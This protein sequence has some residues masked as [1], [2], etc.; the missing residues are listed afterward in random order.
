MAVPL[1]IHLLLRARVK[2][3]DW[4][5][6]RFLQRAMLRQKRQLRLRTL[7]QLLAR[8][9]IIAALVLAAAQPSMPS[10]SGRLAV[11]EPVQHLFL[12]D[13]SLSSRAVDE[14]DHLSTF[15][16][17]REHILNIV[18]SAQ[19][20]DSFQ[21]WLHGP[22]QPL[23]HRPTTDAVQAELALLKLEPS[24]ERGNLVRSLNEL[25]YLLSK[26]EQ[27]SQD[28][29]IAQPIVHV[30]TDMQ[31]AQW[32][33]SPE[34]V[35]S[36]LK[37]LEQQADL[38]II[39]VGSQSREN[40]AIVQVEQSPNVLQPWEPITLSVSVRNFGQRRIETQV[41]FMVD[42][43]TRSTTPVSLEA[44]ESKTVTM[45]T[46]ISDI[47]WHGIELLLKDDALNDDNHYFTAVRVVDHLNVLL[48]DGTPATSKLSRPCDFIE[49][50]LTDKV[51][52]N[53][54]WQ[55]QRID[56]IDLLET[57]LDNFDLIYLCDL[58]RYSTHE[59][60]RLSNFLNQGGGV[61]ISLGPATDRENLNQ[62]FGPLGTGMLP[63][64]LEPTA[65]DS[66]QDPF[67]LTLS[68]PVQPLGLPFKELPESFFDAARAYQFFP[69]TKS[70]DS[71]S[72]TGLV[73]VL[74]TQQGDAILL[75]NS[76][77]QKQPTQ[78]K[79]IVE[80]PEQ[81]HLPNQGLGR[82][83]LITTS[84]DEQWGSW[85]AWPGFLPLIHELS[86]EMA[87]GQLTPRNARNRTPIGSIIHDH[88]WIGPLQRFSSDAVRGKPVI[89]E[90]TSPGLY[91]PADYDNEF[92]GITIANV[93]LRDSDLMQKTQS[94]TDE[95]TGP[96]ET[97]VQLTQPMSDSN[98]TPSLALWLLL[99][100]M[101]FFVT[102]RFL[103]INVPFGVCFFAGIVL[104]TASQ[105][106]ASTTPIVT[107]C[108]GILTSVMVFIAMRA[109]VASP[110]IKATAASD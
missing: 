78:T 75:T 103:A 108:I 51:S 29:T 57:E 42:G 5:A 1:A 71:T 59:A 81:S 79:T 48:V 27:A 76:R 65:I 36:G 87:G 83:A 3:I 92:E 82:L 6:M 26:Y 4:G 10:A 72:S 37:K 39:N 104:A 11:H 99:A 97:A 34:A 43:F 93:D 24:Q 30:L 64:L 50:A 90:I 89:D 22:E 91:L 58:P 53:P 100:A 110:I 41:E 25:Q 61:V 107:I 66:S 12:L 94:T 80:Q 20:G 77:G 40:A 23:I 18:R 35:E 84:L 63:N 14:E 38:E 9:G 86:L 8:M 15:E 102:D 32:E 69:L 17:G 7:L 74:E 55:V 45:F 56:D 46:S 88:Q 68:V 60:V 49:L 67:K 2:R 73:P 33:Q 106:V 13:A 70:E 62:L 44:R 95:F 98:S 96:R 85:V 21:V 16:R 19:T 101:A 105:F 47:G 28:G 52:A 54:F 109:F 31:R